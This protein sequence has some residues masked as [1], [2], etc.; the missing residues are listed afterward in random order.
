MNFMKKPRTLNRKYL[1]S[2]FAVVMAVDLIITLLLFS[3]FS[4]VQVESAKNYSIAHLEQM[5]TETDI[6][7]D[8]LESITNQVLSDRDTLAVLLSTKVDRLQ[9]HKA[10]TRLKNLKNAYPYFR[11][12]GM[13]NAVTERYLSNSF[14][15]D[16][17]V[18]SPEPLYQALGDGNFASLLRPIGAAYSLQ[19]ARTTT[20]YTFVFTVN[21]RGD[22]SRDLIIIDVD[23]SFFDSIL[24]NIRAAGEYQEVLFTDDTGDIISVNAA[25]SGQN[26]FSKAGESDFD[27]KQAAISETS[28]SVSYRGA[29]RQLQFVTF[30]RAAR[31]NWIV[32][33]IVPYSNI[34][35]DF[36]FIVL[37]SCAMFLVTLIFG[38]FLS[39]RVSGTLYKPIRNLYENYVSADSKAE[40]RNELEQLR[41]AFSGMYSRAN[42]LEQGLIASYT[43]S[44]NMY[45]NYIFRGEIDT[46]QSSLDIYSHLNIRLDSPFYTT[47]LIECSRQ[48]GGG[49]EGVFDNDLFVYHYALENVTRDVVSRFYAL[50]LLRKDENTFAVLI[51]LDKPELSEDFVGSLGEIPEIMQR[52]FSIDTTICIGG[53]AD[54]WQ[55]VNLSYEQ[56]RIGMK[57]HPIS[58]TGKAF[59][60]HEKND[61]MSADQYFGGLHNK[62]TE[63][64]K[65]GNLEACKI[66]FDTALTSMANLSFKTALS[67]SRH[68]TMSVLDDFALTFDRDD[69][70]FRLLLSVIEEMD[71]VQNVRILIRTV[72]RFFSELIYRVEMNR[73]NAGNDSVDKIKAYLECNYSNPDISLSSLAELVNLTPAYLGKIFTA[74]TGVTFNEYLNKTRMRKACELLLE[75]TLPVSKISESVGILNSSYFFS[76]FKKTY[77]IT[78]TKYRENK[79]NFESV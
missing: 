44:K 25:S 23:A 13:Y 67:Y 26:H 63:Y 72:T 43:Q 42:Q 11:Y 34:F 55:S 66:E 4:S 29:D 62:F 2:F 48:E 10:C 56:A 75:T 8:S 31:M 3:V 7:Y 74:S 16:N 39:K 53:I 40:K 58:K 76:L 28:G 79:K 51:Y 77:N 19:S 68:M 14:V 65:A 32:I 15:S 9:E 46:I 30:A 35:K 20:A 38:F 71:S 47:L 18:F 49:T 78:P 5:C 70:S 17:S 52:E 24:A 6:L 27:V 60:Y 57:S 59:F 36:G 1:W 64:V 37:L 50:E 12:V 61:L 45:L 22:Q 41:E 54:T 69:D 33:N 73:K 21:V